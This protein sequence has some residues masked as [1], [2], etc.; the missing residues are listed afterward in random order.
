MYDNFTIITSMFY[1]YAN[2]A[3]STSVSD[4]DFYVIIRELMDSVFNIL[5]VLMCQWNI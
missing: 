2:E 4:T 5:P 3:V 1:Y